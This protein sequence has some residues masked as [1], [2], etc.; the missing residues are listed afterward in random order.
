MT[1]A[2]AWRGV[3]IERL[4]ATG[5]VT[6]AAVCHSRAAIKGGRRARQEADSVKTEPALSDEQEQIRIEGLRILA[7]RVPRTR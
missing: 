2:A 1:A 6:L 4:K 5:N 3:F 7:H